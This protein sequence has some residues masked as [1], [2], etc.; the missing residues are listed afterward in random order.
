MDVEPLDAVTAAIAER[1]V[2]SAQRRAD[3]S[4]LT[5]QGAA[6]LVEWAWAELGDVSVL[7]NNAGIIRRAPALEAIAED[8]HATIALNLTAPFLLKRHCLPH[9]HARGWGRIVNLT[10]VHGLRASAFKAAWYWVL[11]KQ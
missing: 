9:M 3:L 8:W 1:G 4:S 11:A 5:P 6:E 10:S 2:C 7:V